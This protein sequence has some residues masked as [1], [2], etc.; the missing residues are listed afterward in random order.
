MARNASDRTRP[1]VYYADRRS[2]GQRDQ[3]RERKELSCGESSLG[4]RNGCLS[5]CALSKMSRNT[6]KKVI[7]S[8]MNL[9]ILPLLPR[10]ALH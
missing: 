4:R 5:M 9:S 7:P 8:H 10:P 1:G 3:V 6:Y 2:Q